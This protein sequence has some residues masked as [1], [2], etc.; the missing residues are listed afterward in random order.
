MNVKW[1]LY[2]ICCIWGDG[3]QN[4]CKFS[5]RSMSPPQPRWHGDSDL[6]IGCFPFNH[7]P[8]QTASPVLPLWPRP[9]HELLRS[10]GLAFPLSA[11]IF[12]F[13]WSSICIVKSFPSRLLKPSS[14][15]RMSHPA[16]LHP[17]LPQR[18]NK[19]HFLWELQSCYDFFPFIK[20]LYLL[21][22]TQP[23]SSALL[24]PD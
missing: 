9:S 16:S 13:P 19:V 4:A 5:M 8:A 23:Q 17:A 21:Q 3:R 2:N 15:G 12:I 7:T 24:L 14:T 18:W 11:V 20:S 1:A 6:L 22:I 10:V